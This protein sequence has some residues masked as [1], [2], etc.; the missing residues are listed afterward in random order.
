[1]TRRHRRPVLLGALAIAGLLLLSA[2][3]SPVTS[4]VS[5]GR[6]GGLQ[7][8]INATRRA[9]GLGP[10]YWDDT[11]ANSSRQWAQF[12]AAT[13][14]FTHRDL[15][16]LNANLGYPYGALG[17][18]LFAGGCDASSAEIHQALMASSAHRSVVLSPYFDA[19]GVGIAC[20]AAGKL[21]VVEDFGGA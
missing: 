13:N 18:N 20:T 21:Y 3:A 17:E 12:L 15:N 4:G 9:A 5:D 11:L 14:G 2:C 16:A 8:E 7:A 10:V 19:L 1:M 6:M